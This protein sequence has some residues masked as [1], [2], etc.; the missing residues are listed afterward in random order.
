MSTNFRNFALG[1]T[2][3]TLASAATRAADPAPAQSLLA[4]IAMLTTHEWNAQLPDSPDGKK[5]SIHARFTWS[6]NKQTVR[7]ANELVIDGKPKPYVDGLYYWDPEKKLIAF[8]YVGA[9]GDFTAGTVRQENGVLVHEFR[10]V[11]AADG[12]AEEYVARVTPHGNESW[13]N[14]I[15]ARHGGALK[16]I[17]QVQYLPAR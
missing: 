8:V 12:K 10:E 7:I 9:E 6:E 13:D 17:V 3:V 15:F 14:A 2:L 1:F 11:H 5:M 16:Q 4:P